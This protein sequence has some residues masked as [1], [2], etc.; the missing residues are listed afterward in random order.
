MPITLSLKPKGDVI[1]SS[2]L[3][4]LSVQFLWTLCKNARSLHPPSNREQIMQARAHF[5]QM[6]LKRQRVSL[7]NPNSSRVPIGHTSRE[8]DSCPWPVWQ[9]GR[10]DFL[11]GRRPGEWTTV[12]TEVE[13]GHRR[14]EEEK[15]ERGN[16]GW[17]W[18][19]DH[20]NLS[21]LHQ[22]HISI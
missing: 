9:M 14:E 1:K 21:L 4:N 5:R 11:G 16:S 20:Y 22:W 15:R 6:R 12:Y 3:S 7:R 18:M 8:Q 10:M 13:K 17:L 2:V 19:F